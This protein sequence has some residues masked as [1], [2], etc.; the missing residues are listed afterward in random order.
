MKSRKKTKIRTHAVV[1]YLLVFIYIYISISHLSTNFSQIHCLL[2]KLCSI[3]EQ[4]LENSGKKHCIMDLKEIIAFDR[5]IVFKLEP[6]ICYNKK[7]WLTEVF[8]MMRP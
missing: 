2:F 8:F 5:V 3:I 7:N 6:D 1:F 4:V